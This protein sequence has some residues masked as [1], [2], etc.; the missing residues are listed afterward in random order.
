M[1]SVVRFYRLKGV[2]DYVTSKA[3]LEQPNFQRWREEQSQKDQAA[4]PRAR[5]G[6]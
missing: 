2:M 5:A 3:Y 6:T 1:D 4:L